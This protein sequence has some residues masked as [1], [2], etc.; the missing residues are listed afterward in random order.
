MYGCAEIAALIHSISPDLNVYFKWK[1][2]Q[3]GRKTQLS[4][5]RPFTE[6]ILYSKKE[7]RLFMREI[8]IKHVAAFFEKDCWQTCGVQDLIRFPF[9]QLIVYLKRRYADK[10]KLL[11]TYRES[12]GRKWRAV[13][14]AGINLFI[15]HRTPTFLVPQNC[16]FF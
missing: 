1:G 4:Q 3:D 16:R 15:L 11:Y 6:L 2:K 7:H 14:A 13:G 5:L 9:S 8:F 10:I 12:Y